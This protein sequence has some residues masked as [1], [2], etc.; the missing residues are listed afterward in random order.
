MA[1]PS[2]R[3]SCA[4]FSNSSTHIC[5]GFE[6]SA[7]RVWNISQPNDKTNNQVKSHCGKPPCFAAKIKI[8][9]D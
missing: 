5:G 9:S 2:F 7:V 1:T 4:T 6:D 3:L 8:L